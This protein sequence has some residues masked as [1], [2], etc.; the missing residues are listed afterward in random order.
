MTATERIGFLEVGLYRG[1]HHAAEFP[2]A[3]RG[4]V[5]VVFDAKFSEVRAA[6]V[7]ALL[8]MSMHDA[9]VARWDAKFT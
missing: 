7:S 1:N 2:T 4:V 5:L 6:R 9:A 8:N 3:S